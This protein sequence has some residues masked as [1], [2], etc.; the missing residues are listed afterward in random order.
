[1]KQGGYFPAWGCHFLGMAFLCV[2]AASVQAATRID[3]EVE[4]VQ[5]RP[6]QGDERVE[7]TAGVRNNGSEPATQVYLQLDVKQDGKRVDAIKD[8]PVLSHLPRSGVGRSIPIS[9]GKMA[10]G[11]YDAV[12]KVDPENVI[13]ETNESNNERSVHFNVY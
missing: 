3:L 2:G 13:S 7:I 11:S 9:L 1:M 10:P 6:Y 5:V 8:I 4:S 12:V